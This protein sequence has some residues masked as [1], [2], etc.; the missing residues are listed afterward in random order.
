VSGEFGRRGERPQARPLPARLDPRAGR[1]AGHGDERPPRGSSASGSGGGQRPPLSRRRRLVRSGRIVAAVASFLVLLGSG[2]G[3]AEYRSFAS[4]VRQVDALGASGPDRDGSAQNILLI[5][6]D[7]RPANASPE[8]L[9]ELSTQEDGGSVNTDTLMVLHIPAGGGQASV[10]SIPRDSWVSI[11]GAGKGKI[12]SAFAIGSSH[13][14]G[15]AGGMKSLIQTVQNL[16]GLTVDHFVKVSL[17][18][19][20]EIAQALGPLQVCLNEPAKDPYSGVDL[21]A[22]VS[23]LNA[24]Q[25]LSFVR[26]RHG[27]PRGDL[28]R[29]VRQQYFLSRELAKVASTGVLLNPGKLNQLLTAVSDAL[30]T[31]PKLDLLDFATQFRDISAGSVR[32]AT[33]P[34]TGTP[35]IRDSD[36]NNVSI[37]AVDTVAMPAFFASLDGVRPAYTGAT[38]ADPSS[39]SVRVVNGTG[40]AGLASSTGTSLTRLGFRVAGTSN[41]AS[42]TSLTTVTYQAGKEAQAK[43][44]ADRVPGALVAAVPGVSPVTLTLGTDGIKVSSSSGSASSGSPAP[45]SAS[46]APAPSPAPAPA[47]SYSSTSCIN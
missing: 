32:F 40:T 6:D 46:S 38:A 5:G 15:D 31:D 7:S 20:Y 2:Y 19:F 44:V 37:V 33:I 42:T 45:S 8:V 43:A 9:A 18:G 1:G 11:P 13:G 3:W 10:V 4:G 27:L 28:D 39:V 29:E 26:Q 22:G 23:T 24:K 35:T 14:G 17:L 16:T 34:T 41:A 36:G 21:P 25:A 12:N 30:E 47:K